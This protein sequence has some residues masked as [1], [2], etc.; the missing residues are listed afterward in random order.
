MARNRPLRVIVDTNVVAYYLLA[1]EPFVDEVT[2]FWH[3][4][5][6]PAAPT[7]WEAEVSN[8]LWMAARTGLI[9][10]RLA[11]RRLGMAARLGIRSV[12]IRRLWRG[13]LARAMN[14]NIAAYD[15]LFVE[16]AARERRPLVTFDANLLAAFPNVAVRPSAV[17]AN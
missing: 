2:T 3:R 12:P 16:L 14:S 13:A 15:T 6:D 4:P 8:V 9:D 5:L 17:V 10:K 7:L 11:L 1:T